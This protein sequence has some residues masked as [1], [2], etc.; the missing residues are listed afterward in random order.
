MME[1]IQ[2][3]VPSELAQRLRQHY[4]ALPQIL[5]WGLR[6]LEQESEPGALTRAAGPDGTPR[7]ED[8]LAAL[9]STGLLVD[10]D[11]AIATEY[12][13]D[14]DQRRYTP[15]RVAGKP[16]S[17]MIIAERRERWSNDR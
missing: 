14:A 3:Q 10:L 15:I 4:D 11:P 17:E 6:H 9:R 5:E 16:L 7:R 1:T 13:A 12:R 8:V 2:V